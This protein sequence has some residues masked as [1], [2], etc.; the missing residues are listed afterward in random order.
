VDP[1]GMRLEWALDIRYPVGEAILA[2]TDG[3]GEDEIVVTAA[4][5]FLYGI[6]R[7]V[8]PAPAF[9]YE[10]DGATLATSA[11]EDL[12]EYVTSETLHANWAPVDGATSYEYAVI[13]PGGAFVTRPNF[14]SAGAATSVSA[15]GLPLIAGRRYLFAVRAIGAE[16]SSSE[17]LSDGVVVLEDPC[18]AC[19]VGQLCVDMMCVPDPCAE[20]SCGGGTRCVDGLCVEDG[21]DGGTTPG[22]DGGTTPPRGGSGGGCCS[23]ITSTHEDGRAAVA[24]AA[25]VLALVVG[26]RR[27]QT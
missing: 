14:V 10:N 8:I 15:T 1:C 16:G 25:L 11:A 22:A 17:A 24:L 4:D 26:R 2:D 21:A 6:D 18:D 27:R 5:G 13:T 19:G 20:I 7:E 3:D 23:V 9:V 12:D